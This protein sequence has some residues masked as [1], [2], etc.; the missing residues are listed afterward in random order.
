MEDAKEDVEEDGLGP[1][2]PASFMDG[3]GLEYRVLPPSESAAEQMDC[4]TLEFSQSDMDG[5]QRLVS[6]VEVSALVHEIGPTFDRSSSNVL[7]SSLELMV[8]DSK[9]DAEHP[10]K[11]KSE[12]ESMYPLEHDRLEDSDEVV[13]EDSQG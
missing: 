6:T 13:L 12:G 4:A 8:V 2:T 9:D 1:T 10:L 7:A 3:I 11:L 5:S